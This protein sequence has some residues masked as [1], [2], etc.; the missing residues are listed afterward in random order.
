MLLDFER[1][2]V[3]VLSREEGG[4]SIE[5]RLVEPLKGFQGVGEEA[6]DRPLGL[7]GRR[8]E[9]LGMDQSPRRGV[10]ARMT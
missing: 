4:M 3:L 8:R 6:T 7:E 10:G 5:P 2:V 9:R 1:M